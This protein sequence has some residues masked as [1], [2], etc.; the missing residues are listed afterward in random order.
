MGRIEQ[1]EGQKGS[2]KWIQEVINKSPNLLNQPI[3]EL[4]LKSAFL[5]IERKLS[6]EEKTAR[7]PEERKISFILDKIFIEHLV[8]A[9]NQI[10][11]IYKEKLGVYLVTQNQRKSKEELLQKFA[12]LH[13]LFVDNNGT[14]SIIR[15]KEDEVP[16]DSLEAFALW[17]SFFIQLCSRYEPE[18]STDIKYLTLGFE[19]K[20]EQ[21]GFYETYDKIKRT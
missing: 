1:G 15:G 17:I 13:N 14:I 7:S 19:D 16:T 6:G 18:L 5:T 12:L 8:Q 9:F 10:A 4:V 21:M 2:L 11:K 3:L 20:L